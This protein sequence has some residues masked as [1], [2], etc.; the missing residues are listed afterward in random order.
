MKEE[1]S[2]AR[3]VDRYCLNKA[4]GSR[5]TWHIVLEAEKEFPPFSPGDSVG[6]YPKNAEEEVKFLLQYFSLQ[7][8]EL[9]TDKKGNQ[10]PAYLWFR[11]HV[12]IGK[13][14]SSLVQAVAGE[15]VDEHYSLCRLLQQNILK[16][17]PLELVTKGLSSLRPRL[18]S[19]ASGPSQGKRRIELIVARALS[20]GDGFVHKGVCSHY[21]I[22]GAPLFEP[23]ISL[24]HQPT[25]HFIF[26]K[27]S[28][29]IM[30]GAGT[31]I[32]PFRAYMQEVESQTMT[33]EKC[34][35]FF[36]ER[37]STAD[38][39]YEE[40]WKRQMGAGR[41]RLHVAFSYDQEHKIYVQHRMWQERE[42]LWNWLEQG[43]HLYICGHAQKMAKDVEECL[44]EIACEEGSMKKEQAE[45]WII[46]L[47]QKKRYLKD[48]Y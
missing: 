22:E 45:E 7:G 3:I 41:L 21:L 29:L 15:F 16:K 28:P 39:F 40:F 42:E 4:G 6:I 17:V 13:V 19:I 10:H 23:G 44:L 5:E 37:K 32:A 20:V 31:G 38:F 43:A 36:G 46:S 27:E 9:L 34:W 25:R 18:Y 12:E 26:P 14:S 1:L 33:P 47:K 11:D 30:V 48:V 35:L 24:F 8:D 2:V